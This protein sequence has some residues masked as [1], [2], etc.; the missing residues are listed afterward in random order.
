MR[1]AIGKTLESGKVEVIDTARQ[2]VR[3]GRD[4][5]SHGRLS[6]EI[7]ERSVEAFQ[8]FSRTIRHYE[9]DQT[10][11]VAT[12][13]VRE[14]ANGRELTDR[15]RD[16]TDI[17]IDVISGIQEARLVHLAVS[18]K[19]DMERGEAL[20]VD[21]GGGSVEVVLTSDGLLIDSKSYDVGTVRML[22]VLSDKRR[23]KERFAQVVEEVC[24]DVRDW[25]TGIVGHNL[26]GR[27]VGT[28]GNVEA[29]GDL[30][31]RRAGKKA[32]SYA[33]IKDID[34]TRS[35]LED[36]SVRRR[37]KELRLK[38]DR[39]DVIYPATVVLQSIMSVVWTSTLIIPRVGLREGLLADIAMRR[40]VAATGGM[41]ALR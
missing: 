7:I 29:I 32:M 1:L 36:L 34:R 30:T 22:Q 14:A 13:A 38:L 5:F 35:T 26:I 4:V 20:L 37:R 15:V 24:G 11:A 25:V 17:E 9:V 8:E 6:P 23:G 41:G 3:L 39:A 27:M 19:L 16:E 12:S 28:G 40:E 2:P 31:G 21:I 18:Q 33:N 10:A